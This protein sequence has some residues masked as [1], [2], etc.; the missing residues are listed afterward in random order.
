[1][2]ATKATPKKDA[3][4]DAEKKASK[5]KVVRSPKWPSLTFK[6]ALDKA[7]LIYEHE[8]RAATTPAVIYQHLGFK[9]KTGPAGRT[10][11][12]L[13]Q[14][15]LLDKKEKGS[16]AV[17]DKAFRLFHLPEDSPERGQIQRDLA[18][19]PALFKEI[20]AKYKATGLPSDSTLKS[21]LVL[22]RGFNAN[23][24]EP[25]LKVF[26][27][28]ISIA[29]PFDGTYTPPDP[30]EEDEEEEEEELDG[31]DP[32]EEQPRGKSALPPPP[33]PPAKG[34]L[35]FPL[36]LSKSQ[37]AMLYVPSAMTAKEFELLKKQIEN[38][39]LVMEATILS[40]EQGE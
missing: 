38:S 26:Q 24:V 17:S 5:K 9:K 39:F 34:Q 13:G 19:R 37:K 27:A 22:D 28:A 35:P 31:F 2:S 23:T 1:M 29:K 8:H 21:Y 10:L 4:D 30:E 25:F 3:A 36:Y 18:L 20:I 7:K 40:D 15:G 6:E 33:P 14:Y 12:A 11:S 32:P 16:Y